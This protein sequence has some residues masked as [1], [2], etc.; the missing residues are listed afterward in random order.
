MKI[1]KINITLEFSDESVAGLSDHEIER[2]IETNLDVAEGIF[3]LGA[4]TSP[5]NVDFTVEAD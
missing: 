4:G 1:V 3:D 2:M 5:K